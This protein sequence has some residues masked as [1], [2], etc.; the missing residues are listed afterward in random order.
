MGKGIES[1]RDLRV[2]NEAMTLAEAVYSLSR[3]LPASERF[4]LTS[5][6]TRAA[7]SVPANIAEGHGSNHTTVFR[8]HLS[9]ARGSLMELETH[10]ILAERTRLLELSQVADALAQARTVGM[11]LNG[12]IRSLRRSS[13]DD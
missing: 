4:G 5:Q 8:N 7:V 6:M 12:L 9:I 11:L 3:K 13:T 2:W 1:Y 10:L